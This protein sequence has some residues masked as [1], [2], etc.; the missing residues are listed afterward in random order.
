VKL[1]QAFGLFA[2]LALVAGTVSCDDQVKRVP[3]FKTMNRQVS[4][5]TYEAA[6]L[7]PPEGAVPLGAAMHYDLRAADTLLTNPVAAAPAAV[8]RGSILYAQFCIMCHGATG[9]GDGPVVGDNRFPVGFV[10]MNLTRPDAMA[11]SDGYIFGIIGNGRG[12][13]PSY[14]RIPA[15]ERWY[16]VHYVRSLQ[17]VSTSSAAPAAAD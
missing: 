1:R 11:L 10:T 13:M 9:A 6:A 7:A 16:L 4:V 8:E 15:D 14:R 3:W 17:G 5:E 12:L 2:L